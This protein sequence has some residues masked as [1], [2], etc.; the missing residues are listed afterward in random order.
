MAA[1]RQR[2]LSAC[3]IDRCLPQEKGRLKMNYTEIHDG[4]DIV[5]LLISKREAV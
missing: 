3:G 5:D 1:A 4:I 2:A